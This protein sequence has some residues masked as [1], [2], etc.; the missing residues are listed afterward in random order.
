MASDA[1]RLGRRVVAGFGVGPSVRL[2]GRESVLVV[3]PSQSGKTSSLVVPALLSWTGPVV[4]TS[5]KRDVLVATRPWRTALGRVT[6]LEPGRDDGLTWDPMEGVTTLR[7]ALRVARELAHPEGGRDNADFW[8]ALAS[9]LV[10]ALMV[11]AVELGRTI[12]DVATVVED[13][14][15]GSWAEGP[16]DAARIVRSFLDHAPRTLDGVA[17]TAETMLLA[18]RFAQPCARVRDVVG[19]SHSLYLCA[20][21]A[22]IAHFEG[23]LRGAL[24]AVLDEQRARADA[25]A[26]LPLLLAL[27]EAV[28]VAPL[29]DLDHLAATLASQR[30]T[31]VTVAQDFAQIASRFGDRAA[32]IV[33]NHSARVVLA[34]LTDPTAARYLPEAESESS[35]LRRR[36]PGTAVVVAG[37]RPPSVVALRPWWRSRR[38]RRRGARAPH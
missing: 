19:G 29:D 37:S 28:A 6:V 9:K 11:R 13:R 1:I 4:V 36:P 10:A 8:N 25:G 7:H 17:T 31:L 22:E 23:L 18:W 33:N 21:R 24:R 12:F 5:V 35:P 34:G 27:D 32:T 14:E 30:V 16:G 26:A 38:L 20:P 2:R 3:G 15:F